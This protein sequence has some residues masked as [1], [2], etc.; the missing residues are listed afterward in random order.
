MPGSLRRS[1]SLPPS[2]QLGEILL[3][4]AGG[5]AQSPDRLAPVLARRPGGVG[6][7]PVDHQLAPHAGEP[8]DRGGATCA[9]NSSKA[10]SMG[11]PAPIGAIR[12]GQGEADGPRAVRALA[13]GMTKR[14][15][16]SGAAVAAALALTAA[17]GG[18]AVAG[19]PPRRTIG[20]AI[21][22][23]SQ[24]A[25]DRAFPHMER[26]FRGSVV[27]RGG[28]VHPLPP[29]R[30]LPI[31]SDVVDRFVRRQHV[32][33]LLVLRDGR[34]RLE[35][36]GRGLRPRGRWT[37]F[38]IA[39]SVTA[40]LVGAAIRDGAIRSVDD[41]VTIYLPQLAASAYQGVTVAQLLTMTSGVRWNEDYTDPASDVARLYTSPVASGTDPTLA[42]MRRLPRVAPPG[43][44]WAY[45]T[46]ETDLVGVLVSTVTRRH[47]AAYLSDRIWRPYGM[48]RDA[49]WM[50]DRS[51]H[52]A[53]GCCLSMTLRD[54]GR[55]GQL[56]LDDGAGLM[57]KGWI[58]SATAAHV[59]I[60]D[61]GDGYGYQW[62]TL[63]GHRVAAIGIFGQSM[64]ID[65]EHRVVIV[66]L[67]TWPKPVDAAL[68]RERAAFQQR[69]IEAAT[70]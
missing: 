57:P 26:V 44:T 11:P 65:P 32:A 18:P 25:H 35:R 27:R 1:A 54:Y 22:F 68:S 21:L 42:Y 4:E 59:A 64:L 38:S 15:R 48:A 17:I 66:M 53:G 61:A 70:R 49:F 31:A 67:G 28:R 63:P 47:L 50:T 8:G 9:S 5:G 45:K 55:L 56:V 58:A 10:E 7:G 30:P 3:P 14:A 12:Q 13:G 62:W 40:L 19:A 51:G 39:K 60:D 69:L 23:W 29:G 36:Y 43:T 46:G 37:S 6:L 52:E 34:V 16:G 20:S 41:L 2:Q 24:A 33:G